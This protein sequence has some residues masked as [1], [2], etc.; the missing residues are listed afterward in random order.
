[1]ATGRRRRSLP[2]DGSRYT[3][4][5]PR[6]AGRRGH[7]PG[8][9]CRPAAALPSPAHQ[10]GDPASGPAVEQLDR[11]PRSPPP[12]DHRR[13]HRPG[14]GAASSDARWVHPRPAP[15][16]RPTVSAT[17]PFRAPCPRRAPGRACDVPRASTR[18]TIEHRQP[19]V[20][21]S[22]C[23]CPEQPGSRRVAVPGRDGCPPGTRCGCSS[24][25]SRWRRRTGSTRALL[26]QRP[27]PAA[28]YKAI[29][30]L[31]QRRSLPA[32]ASATC[33]S[34]GTR[35]GESASPTL[36]S[37]SGPSS[38]PLQ[39]GKVQASAARPSADDTGP[40]RLQHQP[41][42]AAASQG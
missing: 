40:R 10:V 37:R 41:H 6:I 23:R 35:N 15:P 14:R 13:D 20:A 2:D 12:S 8:R 28:R 9:P 38:Q 25:R 11:R 27:L 1:M 33:T 36:R 18:Q 34:R 29:R 42:Q 21:S 7:A 4:R 16:G 24:C 31:R 26:R 17:A 19:R 32:A 5:T 3:T 22:C 30:V 39:F